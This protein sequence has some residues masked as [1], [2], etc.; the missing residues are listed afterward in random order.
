MENADGARRIELGK[1]DAVGTSRV[2]NVTTKQ[3]PAEE[4]LEVAI[5][6][7]G[8]RPCRLSD[9]L[10]CGNANRSEAF[11]HVDPQSHF[12][13]RITSHFAGIPQNTQLAGSTFAF[14]PSRL[15]RIC[16]LCRSIMGESK[17]ST[18]VLH[19]ALPGSRSS[20]RATCA[21]KDGSATIWQT[22][23]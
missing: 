15:R 18:Q 23:A 3:Q 6:I 20:L 13:R 21:G 10:G 7:R 4:G 8:F 19:D 12:L 9:F 17:A 22:S 2:T 1:G 5:V 14:R 11:M 16:R